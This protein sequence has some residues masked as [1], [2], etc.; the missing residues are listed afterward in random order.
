LA[1]GRII[2]HWSAQ[3]AGL[4]HQVIQDA[5]SALQQTIHDTL[6]FSLLRPVHLYIY[7]NRA[8]FLAGAPGT[9]AAETGA[10]AVP[11]IS[12]VYME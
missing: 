11:A 9:N 2:V 5:R 7:A 3:A 12:I 4:G 1:D 6:G 10:L 8:D